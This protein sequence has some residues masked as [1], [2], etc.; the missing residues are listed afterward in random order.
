MLVINGFCQ[1]SSL[2]MGPCQPDF[3]RLPTGRDPAVAVIH[4]CTGRK[5]R[6]PAQPGCQPL[7]HDGSAPSQYNEPS[8]SPVGPPAVPVL[9]SWH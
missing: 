5:S 6:A 2:E 4:E 9:L 8:A 1:E 7:A 3:T